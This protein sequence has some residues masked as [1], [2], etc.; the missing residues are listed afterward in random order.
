M[1]QKQV[2]W[3]P[4]ALDMTDPSVAELPLVVRH[5][6]AFEKVLVDMPIVI[7]EGDLIVGNC[8]LEGAIVR[9]SMP[10]YASESERARARE[11]GSSIGSGL[12]HKTPYYYDVINKGLSAIMADLDHKISEIAGRNK[13]EGREKKMAFFEAV[14]LECQAV[15]GL[16]HRYADFATQQAEKAQTDERRD[17]LLKIADVC[18]RVP[19]FSAQTFHEAVQSFWL[20]HFALY[21]TGTKLSCGRM[22]QYLYAPLKRDLEAGQITLP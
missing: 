19:E 21:S 5:A 8:A 7:E 14:K 10:E 16:A 4:D 3:R 11:E 17:A 1:T 6:K 9:T 13:S 2:A 22:D 20:V 15:I 12:S 18:R